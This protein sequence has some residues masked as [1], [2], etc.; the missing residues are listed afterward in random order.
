[1][2]M[3]VVDLGVDEGDGSSRDVN[4]TTLQQHS[5][6][7]SGKLPATGRWRKVPGKVQIRKSHITCGIRV[8]F[9]ILKLDRVGSL[10][11]N[12]SSL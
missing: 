12:T 3:I 9:A 6:E 7:G 5:T 1:M 10:D 11:V 2:R 4:T 8:N